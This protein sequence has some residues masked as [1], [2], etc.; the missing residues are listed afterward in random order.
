MRWLGVIYVFFARWVHTSRSLTNRK[1]NAKQFW[2]DKNRS[3]KWINLDENR[4]HAELPGTH[5][6]Y[7]LLNIWY[8]SATILILCYTLKLCIINISN[9]LQSLTFYFKLIDWII[10]KSKFWFCLWF[11]SKFYTMKKSIEIFFLQILQH[12]NLFFFNSAKKFLIK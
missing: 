5:Y 11:L 12:T 7:A 2:T 10:S 6:V 4:T 1:S 8:C 9:P 3:L